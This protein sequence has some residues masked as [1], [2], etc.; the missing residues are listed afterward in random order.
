M[1][2]AFVLSFQRWIGFGTAEAERMFW[3]EEQIR[4]KKKWKESNIY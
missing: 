2:R 4:T 3:T 1:G